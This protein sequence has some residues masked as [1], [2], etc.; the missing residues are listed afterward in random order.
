MY[1]TNYM[2]FL[3]L[4][5]L[6]VSYF[7]AQAE[8]PV[9]IVVNPESV[10]KELE[11]WPLGVNVNFLLDDDRNRPHKTRTLSDAFV[12]MGTK[13]IRFPGGEKS[14]NYLW[15][16]PPYEKANPDIARKGDFE[17][18]YMSTLD[19]SKFLYDYDTF[20]ADCKRAGA[21]ANLVVPMDFYRPVSINK[22]GTPSTQ[23]TFAQALENAK[24]WVRYTKEKYPDMVLC[25]SLSNEPWLNGSG[26]QT[27]IKDAD[28]YGVDAAVFAY[29]MK[30]IDPAIKI[31]LCGERPDWYN[32]ALDGF[33]K[34]FQRDYKI[35]E[36]TKYLDYL[37]IHG[38]PLYV[39][40]EGDCVGCG[41]AG[42]SSFVANPTAGI[43]GYIER[44]RQGLTVEYRD[45]FPFIY[46]ETSALSYSDWDKNGADTGHGLAAFYVMADGVAN[47]YIEYVQYWN[48]RWKDD[49][50]NVNNMLKT[51]NELT[52]IGL[53]VSVLGQ[54]L[55]QQMV[56]TVST[57]DKLNTYASYNPQ[58]K[59]LNVF[60]V[61]RDT[62]SA[63]A[64]I[65]FTNY[66]IPPKM[67]CMVYKGDSD[68]DLSPAFTALE[69]A[70]RKGK[71]VTVKLNPVS[72]TLL[73][74]KN[75]K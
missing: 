1:K 54:N 42:Y 39:Y 32:K 6:L 22:D 29:E 46:T 7:D 2:R 64:E 60:I 51:N 67:E 59:D 28:R 43:S 3:F 36:W 61:N 69:N 73:R 65:Q 25:W 13:I 24:E 4:L 58:T 10:L 75:K 27:P 37:D 38:Y 74:F 57:S 21:K 12:D 66:S 26:N 71:N 53:A 31:A 9:K 14:D 30:K 15:S 41:E 16:V 20:I 40:K 35:K 50:E 5:L 56:E 33:K 23:F 45:L 72:I 34:R 68:K 47:P 8:E 55:Y 49:D 17:W 19:K 70:K 62:L 44:A 48:T 18:P 11:V 52:A 63:N